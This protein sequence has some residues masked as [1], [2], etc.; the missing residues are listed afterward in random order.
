MKSRYVV[1]GLLFGFILSRSG[2]A[3]Y[4]AISGMFRLT[5]LHLFGVIGTAVALTALGFAGFRA[6]VLRPRGGGPALIEPK[7]VVKGL[8]AAGMLFGAGWALTGTCPGT[9]L[10]QIGG[11]HLSGVFT[12]VGVL[13]GAYVQ[14]RRVRVKSVVVPLVSLPGVAHA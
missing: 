8:F 13:L 7:P 9:A 3:H 5:D 14:Q 6:G 2:A 10:S 1:F 11:G 4:D 12:F